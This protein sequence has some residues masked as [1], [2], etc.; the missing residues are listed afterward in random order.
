MDIEEEEI[1]EFE[2]NWI[3]QQQQNSWNPEIIISG[4]SLA[5]IFS[6]KYKLFNA[7]AFMIQEWGTSFMGGMLIF[8]YCLLVVNILQIFLILHLTL[9]FAWA[10][11]LGISYAFPNGVDESKLFEYQKTFNY[12]SPQAMVL[13]LERICSMAF[14]IPLSI[15]LI[16]IPISIFLLIL[17]AIHTYFEVEFF[18]MYLIFMASMILFIIYFL[19]AKKLNIKFKTQGFGASIGAIYTSNIGK[20]RYNLI[21][22]CL[23][24]PSII[25]ISTDVKE[26]SDFFNMTDASDES[27]EW[28]SEELNIEDKRSTNNRF[29]R[30][31]LSSYENSSTY[32]H[33]YVAHYEEDVKFVKQQ[34]EKWAKVS[35]DTLNLIPPKD[36]SDLYKIYIND[37]L[38]SSC[39]WE[40][41]KVGELQQK[42]YRSCVDISKLAIGTHEM[43][44][45]KSIV[46]MPFMFKT[47]QLK[48]RKN[49]AKVR[50]VK[51]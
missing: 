16:F 40:K 21:T 38:V 5:F 34:N 17:I 12:L 25:F 36:I 41:V 14:G 35:L 45:E 7:I 31:L 13:R 1:S 48:V 27:I 43:R 10:S 50:F 15:G 26:F 51:E 29:G 9:R 47:S 42:A 33:F 22:F 44:F 24:V 46:T 49:W 37:T 11:L 28:I 30:I 2:K 19:Y 6:F 4:L 18:I 39:K 8:I 32:A 20:W 3:K 23:L